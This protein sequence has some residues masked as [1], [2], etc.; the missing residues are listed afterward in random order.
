MYDPPRV[1]YIAEFTGRPF[2]TAPNKFEALAAY[3][4]IG[5]AREGLKQLAVAAQNSQ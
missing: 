4:T 5:E 2:C 3:E 1:N